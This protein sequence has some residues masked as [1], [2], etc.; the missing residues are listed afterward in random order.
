MTYT[1][2]PVHPFP[3]TAN[4]CSTSTPPDT[5]SYGT[6]A[7]AVL[8]QNFRIRIQGTNSYLSSYSGGATPRTDAGE[9]LT[10]TTNLANALTFDSLANG[11]LSIVSADGTTLYSDQDTINT[12]GSPIYFD[13]PNNISN[14]QYCALAWCLSQPN[15]IVTVQNTVKPAENVVQICPDP[16]GG[17]TPQVYLVN[18]QNAPSYGCSTVGLQLV[19]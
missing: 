17:S 12:T 15:N 3:T 11:Q 4:T 10:T 16:N 8:G 19:T 9:S 7:C 5:S 18:S 6:N 1:P 13:T 2:P 14:N